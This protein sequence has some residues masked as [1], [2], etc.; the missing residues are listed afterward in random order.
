MSNLIDILYYIC[1]N[2]PHKDE[3]SKA[4]LTK[5]VYLSDW[6]SCLVKDCQ[7]TAID[8]F[9]D[10]YGPFVDDVHKEIEKRGDLINIT[11]TSNCYGYDKTLYMIAENDYIP[12]LEDDEK[13]IIDEVIDKTKTMH[14]D[15]FINFVYSTYPI[16]T[17]PRYS[18]LNLLEKAHEYK[19]MLNDSKSV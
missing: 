6:K 8:W 5:M 2:Y 11:H 14:W 16:A 12:I 19:K 9:F 4:R 1:K 18:K 15:G 10:N 17:S 3:L 13:K 7:L